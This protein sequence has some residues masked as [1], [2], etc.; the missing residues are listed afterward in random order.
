MIL[1]SHIL[2]WSDQGLAFDV[3]VHLGSLM[4]VMFYFRKDIGELLVAWCKS[5][6][7]QQSDNAR[8]AWLI[9]LAT[10]PAGLA[11]LIFNDF[12]E[13]HLR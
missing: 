11:G 9:I 6:G 13:T 3:A 1:P 4:A 2:G 12:I 7:G 10:I 5:C 8:L